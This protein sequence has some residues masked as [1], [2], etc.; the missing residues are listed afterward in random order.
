[1][2]SYQDIYWDGKMVIVANLQGTYTHCPWP[3]N[4]PLSQLYWTRRIQ[5]YL[6]QHSGFVHIINSGI[7]IET[8]DSPN[9]ISE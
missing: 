4:L 5:G 6:V 1:M 3:Y 9:G 2:A 7:P 8:G